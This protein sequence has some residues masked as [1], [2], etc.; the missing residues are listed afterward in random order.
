MEIARG[1]FGSVVKLGEAS[2]KTYAD[3]NYKVCLTQ[4]KDSSELGEYSA[5]D[6]HY[7]LLN[8]KFIMD[9]LS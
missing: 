8:V 4:A 1:R 6:I 7:P 3:S 9:S 5:G 2:R